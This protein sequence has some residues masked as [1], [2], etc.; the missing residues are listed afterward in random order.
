M[1]PQARASARPKAAAHRRGKNRSRYDEDEDEVDDGQQRL[2]ERLGSSSRSQSRHRPR[3]ALSIVTAAKSKGLVRQPRPPSPASSD[4]S[5]RSSSQSSNGTATPSI[6]SSDDDD[7]KTHRNLKDRFRVVEVP[8]AP[9]ATREHHRASRRSQREV[10]YDDEES[11]AEESDEAGSEVEEEQDDDSEEEESEED[12]DYSPPP[13]VRGSPRP[14]RRHPSTAKPRSP[15]RRHEHYKGATRGSSSKRPHRAYHESDAPHADTSVRMRGYKT[16]SSHGASSRSK[17]SSPRRSSTKA[18]APDRSRQAEKRAKIVKC[19]SCE[20]E[21]LSSKTQKLECGDRWCKSCL[22]Q[23]FK[24]SMKEPAQM[25]PKCCPEKCIPVEVVAPSLSAERQVAWNRKFAEF[26]SENRIYCPGKGCGSWIP[27]DR[28][29]RHG[30]RYQATCGNC[31]TTVCCDCNDKWHTKSKSC[32]PRES[33]PMQAMIDDEVQRCPGCKK[34]V[35]LK[36]DSIHLTCRCNCEFCM[37]CGSV[38]KTC[39]CPWFMSNEPVEAPRVD[40][41]LVP[42][43]S[44]AA[45]PA[46]SDTASTRRPRARAASDQGNRR[47]SRRHHDDTL[48]IRTRARKDSSKTPE[49]RFYDDEDDDDDEVDDYNGGFGDVIGIGNSA[50]HFLNE[51]FRRDP[52]TAMAP[53]PPPHPPF[54]RSLSGAN[55]YLAGVNKARGVRANS[56]ERRLADR[57]SEQRQSGGAGPSHRAFGQS[58]PA[59]P[60]PPGPPRSMGGGGGGGV[61]PYGPPPPP[62]S[63]PNPNSM[64]RRHTMMEGGGGGGD[65]YDSAPPPPPASHR[66]AER[67]FPRRATTF[68]YGDVEGGAGGGGYWPSSRSHAERMMMMMPPPPAPKDSVMAGLG[69]FGRGMGRVHEWAQHVSPGRTGS[70]R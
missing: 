32:R 2:R 70:E 68:D 44:K 56:Q 20:K 58:I 18:N 55:Y 4:V 15:S 9:P 64:V 29:S 48:S 10:V 60:A 22:K 24:R 28:I 46:R 33:T 11:D 14:Q 45:R 52:R 69:G 67:G 23:A 51:D 1:P 57:F 38:W 49:F 12:L 35:P 5:S 26:C 62:P 53:P 19:N 50:G 39:D 17:S 40:R 36:H 42:I 37:A 34:T 25:P 27:P 6:L 30:T 31:D 41:D 43:S 61:G 21:M 13:R 59:P 3:Q 65:L 8:E 54:E 7:E 66:F 16:S 47:R 63:M